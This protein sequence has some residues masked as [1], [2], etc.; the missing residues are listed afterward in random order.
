VGFAEAV[1]KAVKM[2]VIAVGQIN[3]ARQAESILSNGQ[4]DMI[5]LAR[6]ILY[7]P[8]WAWH[9]AQE[10]GEPVTYPRQY[11]RG[12]P[13]RWGGSGINAPGNLIPEK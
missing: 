10:L 7:D 5:A 3:D 13:D 12:H 2:P 8:R 9:A 6:P 11:E 1:K 4:A